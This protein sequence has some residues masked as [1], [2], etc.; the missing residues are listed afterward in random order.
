MAT[1]VC[2]VEVVAVLAFASLCEQITIK[3]TVPRVRFQ[4]KMCVSWTL[5]GWPHLE[6]SLQVFLKL[7]GVA[8][9]G[10][11]C[12]IFRKGVWHLQEGALWQW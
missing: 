5:C 11:E 8:S 10:R 1:A 7:P 6:R 3:V 2:C 4:N 12:G 9:S